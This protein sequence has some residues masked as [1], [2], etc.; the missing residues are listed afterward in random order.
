[1]PGV[2]FI[3]QISLL[4]LNNFGKKRACD[5]RCAIS[6]SLLLNGSLTD[7]TLKLFSLEATWK[8]PKQNNSPTDLNVP[9]HL[10]YVCVYIYLYMQSC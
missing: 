1:M 9:F 7:L 3:L 2:L 5:A 8:C 4:S 6:L 10:S